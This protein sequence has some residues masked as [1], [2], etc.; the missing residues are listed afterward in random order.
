MSGF[1]GW[2]RAAEEPNINSLF[3][4]STEV[5][6]YGKITDY[7]EKENT[8]AFILS[9]AEIRLL[10]DTNE[11]ATMCVLLYMD[12][13]EA[14]TF[15]IGDTVCGEGTI[16]KF[17]KS[18]NPG[19]FD[20]ESYYHA[21]GIMDRVWPD[22]VHLVSQA[23]SY[24]RI[25]MKLRRKWTAVY[26]A[27]LNQ[28]DAGILCAMLT[29][30]KSIL[31]TDIKSLYQQMG[32]VHIL[33]ISGL[34][35]AMIGMAV[36]RLIQYT[37]VGLKASACAAAFF[38][39][40][41]GAMVG[42]GPSTK[43][44]VIM[45]LVRMGAEYFDRSYDMLSALSLSA[46]IVLIQQPLMLMQ[47]GV[48]FSFMAVLSIGVLWP[49]L[50]KL[51]KGKNKTMNWLL[52]KIGPSLAVTAGTVPLTAFYYGAVPLMS[53]ILN[54]IVICLAG[55]IVPTGFFMG[56]V[57]MFCRPLAVFQGGS[58]HVMLWL[59]NHLCRIASSLPGT[60]WRTGSPPIVLIGGYYAVLLIFLAAAEISAYQY[61]KVL[62][63]MA[64][65][66]V[67]LVP[68]RKWEA[69]VAF[70]DV[71]QGD[72][73]FIRDTNGTTWLIDGGSSDV[74]QVGQYRIMPFLDYY[75]EESVDYVCVTHGDEDHLSGIRELLEASRAD[76]L[77]MSTVSDEDTTCQ[78]LAEIAARKMIKII[79]I[80]AGDVWGGSG[81]QMQ[82]LA[83]DESGRTNVKNDQSLVMRLETEAGNFLFTG[84][85]SS[86]AEQKM[87]VEKLSGISVLKVAHHGSA[88]SSSEEFLMATGASMAVISCGRNNH[89]GHP[90]SETLE[91][92]NKA[93]MQVC[94]TMEEGAC[95]FEFYHGSFRRILH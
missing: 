55:L 44:A 1:V 13:E 40:S 2:C 45:F 63:V 49:A 60:V 61:R 57:G 24:K 43:R 59:L 70:L 39:L 7:E 11:E 73:I 33:A 77:V 28:E 86:E 95:I 69:M 36:F 71:G 30:D 4:T 83:P 17:E 92:L 87:D 18:T 62:M 21:R 89:Y 46:L 32:I 48:Q 42:A 76:C 22:S 84:D 37:G 94:L 27:C 93:G 52:G 53:P 26:K 74:S 91:R 64:V 5:S 54:L 6:F 47:V 12:K 23:V 78:E 66:A 14:E 58:L 75:G 9:E 20:A 72:C 16:E 81:W 68:F 25:L 80:Q 35:I 88:G 82:C 79:Y 10:Q 90:A 67:I 38:V 34:H 8:T 85:I 31:D 50:E 51:L 56:I 19:Q 15:A 65:C 3:D 29:G 41:Y